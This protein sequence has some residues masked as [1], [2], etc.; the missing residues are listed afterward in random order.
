MEHIE[1][2]ARRD[3]DPLALKD[4]IRMD[5]YHFNCIVEQVSPY[6]QTKDITL[7]ENIRNDPAFPCNWLSMR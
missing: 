1:S 6:F 2:I 7:C 5:E 3:E 4:L